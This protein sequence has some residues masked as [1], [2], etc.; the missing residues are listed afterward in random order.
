[1][2][3]KSVR[4]EVSK[5]EHAT[6]QEVAVHPSIPQGERPELINASLAYG[7]GLEWESK[8]GVMTGGGRAGGPTMLGRGA[9]T[10][11][12]AGAEDAR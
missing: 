4:A 6:E 1:M 2:L 8:L 12:E 10:G 7:C 5:H 9:G 11:G 3:K